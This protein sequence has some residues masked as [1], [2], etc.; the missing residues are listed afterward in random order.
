[1]FHVKSFPMQT[2][3]SRENPT[4][5]PQPIFTVCDGHAENVRP[6]GEAGNYPGFC[7]CRL[8]HNQGSYHNA[9]TLWYAV[10]KREE[11]SCLYLMLKSL[12]HLPGW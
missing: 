7:F 6:V 1:L 4:L 3:L 11:S 2:E 10:T 12:T 8:D 9:S 5:L